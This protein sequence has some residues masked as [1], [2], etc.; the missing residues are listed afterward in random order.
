MCNY[1][2]IFVHTDSFSGKQTATKISQTIS[3]QSTQNSIPSKVPHKVTNAMLAHWRSIDKCR[4][5][6]Q[7]MPYVPLAWGYNYT[8]QHF[9]K[10]SFHHKTSIPVFNITTTEPL[11]RVCTPCQEKP[12]MSLVECPACQKAREMI[13]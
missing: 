4:Y 10:V 7:G 1:T 6:A 5:V 13:Q 3:F 2:Y 12:P 8:R 9:S 11:C